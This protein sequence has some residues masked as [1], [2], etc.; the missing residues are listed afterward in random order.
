MVAKDSKDSVIYL[1]IP[2]NDEGEDSGN[3][4]WNVRESKLWFWTLLFG[5]ACN[6]AVRSST[7][8]VAPVLT[9]NFN[10]S[11]T[12]TGVILSSFFWGYS[13]TQILGG[14]LA[15]R[16]GPEKMSHYVGF[17]ILV[18]VQIMIGAAQ[19]VFFPS[20]ASISSGNVHPSGRTS[21]FGKMSSGSSF[22]TLFTGCIGSVLLTYYGYS[23]VFYV[24][25]AFVLSWS[26]FLKYYCMKN[27]KVKRVILGLGSGSKLSSIID[28]VPWLI[29]FR[30]PSLWACMIA[31][32][33]QTNCFFTLLSWLPTYFHDNFPSESSWLY[34]TFPWLFC[35]VGVVTANR[36]NNY[37]FEQKLSKCNVR[38]IT[39]GV[40]YVTQLF[41]LLIIGN[42]DISFHVALASL[43]LCLFGAGYHSI[44]ILNNPGDIAPMHTGSVFGIVNC[45]GA[46]PGFIG[47]Y[48]AGYILEVYSGSWSAVYNLTA[49]VNSIGYFTFVTMGSAKPIL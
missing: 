31:H 44:A 17:N 38:K 21:F 20:V 29:Y 24:S 35:I 48:I 43:C 14:Y 46:L 8:L 34:N 26:L 13:L 36:F 10:W 7:P 2:S 15:D 4:Y 27:T 19:G 45:A 28:D 40:C 16:F 25:G 6:Y 1:K 11:K 18:I 42:F 5:T 37:L 47:V 3:S 32:L 22:G 33:C 12:Q 49:F 9:S 23:F 30:S 39:E 41:G